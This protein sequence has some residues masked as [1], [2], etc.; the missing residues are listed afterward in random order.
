MK[1]HWRVIP[2]YTNKTYYIENSFETG[3]ILK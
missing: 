3:K 1:K 2:Q